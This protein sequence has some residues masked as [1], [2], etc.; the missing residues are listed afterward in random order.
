MKFWQ[1]KKKLALGAALIGAI[2]GGTYLFAIVEPQPVI[3]SAVFQAGYS[4]HHSTRS[5]LLHFYTWAMQEYNNG[6]LPQEIDDFLSTKLANCEGSIEC[7]EIVDFQIRQKPQNVSNS[8]IQAPND[9]KKGIIGNI[10]RRLD[11]FSDA[12]AIN[13]LL[14][15]EALR[16][17]RN[18]G[19][20][21]FT[22]IWA[23]Y[24][25]VNP[26]TLVIVKTAF[27]QWWAKDTAWPANKEKNPLEGTGI[28]I[29]FPY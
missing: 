3:A 20:D 23:E 27:R 4:I 28:K 7:Q 8:F 15:I 9:I 10:D 22:K 26:E 16:T 18:L 21:Q 24:P 13:A 25:K 19:K 5:P 11:S 29:Q 1:S 12:E 2:G 6:A 14:L 17:S